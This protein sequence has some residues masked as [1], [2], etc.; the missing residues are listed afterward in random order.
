MITLVDAVGYLGVVLVLIVK[1]VLE[2]RKRESGTT[3]PSAEILPL[4][5][6][7][8]W[9]AG[10]VIAVTLLGMIAFSAQVRRPTVCSEAGGAPSE[11]GIQ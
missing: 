2:Y 11:S 3:V 8:C 5:E 6:A 4:F 9:I 10:G 1:N 7:L